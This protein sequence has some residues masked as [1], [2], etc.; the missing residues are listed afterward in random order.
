MIVN[1]IIFLRNCDIECGDP[2]DHFTLVL[3]GNLMI[4]YHHAKHFDLFSLERKI[5]FVFTNWDTFSKFRM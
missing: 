5:G 2:F 4:M 3:H 1:S